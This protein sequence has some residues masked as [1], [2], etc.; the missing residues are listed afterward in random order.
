VVEAYRQDGLPYALVCEIYA[1]SLLSW[2]TSAKLM[3]SRSQPPDLR[4]M[5][6]LAVS[7]LNEDFLSPSFSTVLTCILDILGRPITS[8]TY[9]AINIGRC[10]AL[11]LSLGLNRNPSSWGLDQRQKSLRIRTWWGLLIHDTW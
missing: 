2:T 10:V 9:N 11:S 7:A 8:I 3:A 5:W 1:V 6:N 4:Y